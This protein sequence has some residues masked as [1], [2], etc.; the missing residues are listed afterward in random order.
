MAR[1]P[2]LLGYRARSHDLTHFVGDP[3][4][5]PT[6][7]SCITGSRQPLVVDS[8]FFMIK[9]LT[10]GS[11]LLTTR[12]K[13]PGWPGV[14]AHPAPRGAA[15]RAALTWDAGR[16]MLCGPSSCT[17]ARSPPDEVTQAMKADPSQLLSAVLEQVSP[18]GPLA[19]PQVLAAFR[20]RALRTGERLHVEGQVCEALAFVAQGLLVSRSAGSARETSCDLFAEGDFA[21][22]YVSFLTGAPST[23]E[24]AALEPCRLLTLSRPELE[25]LYQAV[26]GVERLGRK[27]AERQFV[28]TVH[29][30]GSLLADPPAARYQALASRRPDLL[31]RVPQYLLARWLGVTPESLSRIRG[32]LA[33]QR[34]STSTTAR[35]PSKSKAP[36]SNSGGP[37]APRAP[38]EKP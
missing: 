33:A 11:H 15:G 9:P 14:R 29:R 19:L 28:A 24:L 36:A 4:L 16:G 25:R 38:R 10:P 17:R 35:V 6:F 18:L 31:Q 20:P 30:A 7:D 13:Y 22:D 2:R 3:S 27:I 8:Y 21:T 23:V 12:V 32:R 34:R 37:R 1:R 26:P 5:Q